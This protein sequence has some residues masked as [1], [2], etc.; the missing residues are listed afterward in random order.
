MAS[1]K[2]TATQ[3]G[4]DNTLCARIPD[5]LKGL[6]L[7][8]A[9]ALL[10]PDFSRTL[11]KEHI[12]NSAVWLNGAP[13]RPRDHVRAGDDVRLRLIP[14]AQAGWKAQSLALSIIYEDEDLIVIDKPTGLVVHP[15]AG[16]PAGTLANAL[17]HHA[18]ELEH[19]PR[20]GIVHRLDKDTSGLLVVARSLRARTSLVAQ[21][22]KHRV[23][24]EYEAIVQGVL[25]AGGT[26][27]QPLGR[28]RHRRTRMAVVS[29][30]KQAVTHYRVLR[31]FAAHTHL[32]LAL[33]TGRTHQ[34]RVHLAH[35]GHPLVGDPTYGGR[36]HLPKAA[37]AALTDVL[38]SFKRQAL[39]AVQLGFTHPGTG[40]A[41]SWRSPLPEDMLSLLAAISA[42]HAGARRSR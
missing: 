32:R 18:P 42:D 25:I 40:A 5:E 39:H 20:A 37:D 41:V 19:L 13:A 36:L 21:L 24:R 38:R 8:K 22:Q 2:P 14:R 10:F 17:L 34:I 11:L 9:L 12:E 29:R 1:P 3:A 27:D 16:N 4:K 31:R 33:E 23:T 26:V 7:D 28:H 30:G 15:G 35:I 6:R